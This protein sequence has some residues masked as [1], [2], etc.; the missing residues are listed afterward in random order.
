M[1]PTIFFYIPNDTD[2]IDPD[3]IPQ[4]NRIR[5]SAEAFD[6]LRFQTSFVLVNVWTEEGER[7]AEIIGSYDQEDEG[8]TY[9]DVKRS[10]QNYFSKLFMHGDCWDM[11]LAL[12]RN[13]GLGLGT[14]KSGGPI[15]EG[16]STYSDI[17]HVF[18]VTDDGIRV[19][20]RGVFTTDE[21]FL[22]YTKAGER[23]I[24]DTITPEQIVEA[25]NDFARLGYI[26]PAEFNDPTK[27]EKAALAD[28][29]CELLFADVLNQP[30]LLSCL[31]I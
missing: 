30:E 18:A 31:G 14:V 3:N 8:Y 5:L 20:I 25:C 7:Y 23:A 2:R 9:D 21:E 29:L 28:E 12:H 22:A 19:D 17:S 11:A 1:L 10:V 4:E 6:H 24:F 26:E 13:F 27:Y 15:D 16:D